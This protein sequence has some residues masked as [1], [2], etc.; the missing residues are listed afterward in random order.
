MNIF[1]KEWW[2]N[3]LVRAVKTFCQT[4]VAL[5]PAAAMIT[6]VDWLTALGTSALAFVLSLLTSLGGIPEVPS[7]YRGD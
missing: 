2:K 1:N 6:E 4:M 3:A 7:S 5:I